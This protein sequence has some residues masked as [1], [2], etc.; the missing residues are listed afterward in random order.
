M[1]KALSKNE[2]NQEVKNS[3]IP[4]LIDFYADWCGPCK[5]A[6]PIIEQLSNELEGKV[7]FFKVNVDLERELSRD[8]DVSSIPTFVIIKNGKIEKKFTGL[9][10]KN[11]IRASLNI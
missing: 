4:V 11:E 3:T 6:A 10:N 9:R 8:F 2:F 5:M 1:T 7:K